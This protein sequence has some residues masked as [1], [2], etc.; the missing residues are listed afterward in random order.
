MLLLLI[1]VALY[2]IKEF[3][4]STPEAGVLTDK[5]QGAL[6]TIAVLLTSAGASLSA[7]TSEP[8]YLFVLGLVAAAVAGLKEFLGAVPKTPV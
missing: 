2:A 3:S 4:G 8:L 5:Q 1:P 6:M 7:Q